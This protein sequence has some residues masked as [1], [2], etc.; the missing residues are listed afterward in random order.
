MSH[1]LGFLFHCNLFDCAFS[2]ATFD[3]IAKCIHFL[4]LDF[5]A[6]FIIIIIMVV[7]VQK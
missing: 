6:I 2:L 1:S 3:S 4:L 7:V 5:T